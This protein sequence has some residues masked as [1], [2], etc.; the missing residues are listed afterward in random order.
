[1]KLFTVAQI[2]ICEEVTLLQNKISSI[3]LMEQAATACCNWIKKKYK[4]KQAFLV[5]CGMGNNGGDGL[6]LTRMLLQEGFSAKA[7]VLKYTDKFA[8]NTT[9]NLKLLHQLSPEN[10]EIVNEGH[11][12]SDLPKDIIIID[13]LFGIGLNRPLSGWLAEFVSEI[14]ELPNTKIAIDLP[15]GLP[16]DSIPSSIS[17]EDP[18]I[19]KANFTLSFEFYKRIFLHQET[20]KYAGEIVILEI[21]FSES[22]IKETPAKIQVLDEEIIHSIYKKRSPF[23]NKGSFKN[24]HLIG[25]SFGKTGAITLS[26]LAALRAGGGK[27]FVHAPLCGYPGLQSFV[28]EAMYING[29]K[30][31]IEKIEI[32]DNN[33]IV[34]IGP[35][36]GKEEKTKALFKVFLEKQTA[37]LIIDADALNIIAEQPEL[38]HQIPKNS[39]LSPHPKEFSRLFGETENTMEQ[40]ELARHNAMKFN[41]FIILKNHFTFIAAPDG[42]GWYNITGNAGMATGGSGDVLTGILAALLAQGYSSLETALLGVYIHGL[43]GDIYADENGEESL[44]ARDLA[45][46]LGKAFAKINLNTNN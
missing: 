17:N 10:I 2:K 7:I 12:V 15:S 38:I 3:T 31:F 29:G 19:L 35:G 13:A 14:N 18:S 39:I 9:E 22:Y 42:S 33:D 32:Q 34:A 6:A 41:I 26:T 8:E 27:V 46:N 28:P 30:D 5:L 1:M 45:N 16:I 36:L 11:F 44:I 37:P 4:G 43:S 21:G 40:V 20:A 25:G 23:S 24:I